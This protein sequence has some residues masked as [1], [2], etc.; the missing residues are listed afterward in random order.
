MIEL[1]RLDEGKTWSSLLRYLGPLPA[2]KSQPDWSTD[3]LIIALAPGE[4]YKR[5]EELTAG[6]YIS[7]CG[8]SAP[9]QVW[10]GG[11]LTVED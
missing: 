7:I 3:V 6:T 5:Q 2:M 4:S 1:E 9:Y 11:A 10:P 8:Q